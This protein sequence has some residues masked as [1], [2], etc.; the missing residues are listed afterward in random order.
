M[1]QLSPEGVL[2]VD[3]DAVLALAESG[4]PEAIDVLEKA[5]VPFLA[6]PDSY[7]RDGILAKI[8]LVGT[9]LGKSAEAERLAARVGADI[10]AA[11][12][13]AAGEGRKKRV[14]FLL[15]AAGGKL[16]ASGAGTA[17]DG[18][19]AM[20]GGVNAVTGYRG[21]KP[22]SDEAVLAARPDVILMMENAGPASAGA[23]ILARPAIAATPA[24]QAR[25]LIRMDGAY[26]LGFGPRTAGAIRDLSKALYGDAG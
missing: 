19:I 9:A 6:V 12:K 22:L 2:S 4:P 7:T 13:A 25:R 8:R 20:A 11:E 24:G 10:N 26:L 5:R 1:R 3:P 18:I 21:Y 23:D 16:L 17:A 15:S 14:L